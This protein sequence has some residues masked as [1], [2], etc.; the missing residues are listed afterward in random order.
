[1]QDVVAISVSQLNA[2]IKEVF[3]SDINLM[4]VTLKGEVS[5]FTNHVKTG[6]FYFT[7]KDKTSSIKAIMFKGN[8]SRVPFT[9]ENGMNVVVAGS[10]QV[11][12]RDGA[13]Q[14]YCQTLEPDGVG[15]LYLAFEQLKQKLFDKGLFDL[16]HKKPLPKMPAKIAVATAK[17]GAALQD[18]I[19]VLSRRYPLC[20][21]LVIPTLV[22]GANAPAS[23]I[24]SINKAQAE[25]DVDLLIIG[26]GGGSIEDLW[27]FNDEGV[28]N[29]IFTCKI[30][31]ISAVGHEVD[32]TIADFVA[33]LRAPTPSAAAELAVPDIS[34]LSRTTSGAAAA[35]AHYANL[36][37]KYR[38]DA[39]K[40]A[41]HRLVANSPEAKTTALDGEVNMLS[42]RLALSYA[43]TVDS[44]LQR[45]IKNVSMLD[46]LSPLAVI[47]RGYSITY[48]GEKIVKSAG[49]IKAHDVIKTRFS[50]GEITSIVQETIP[51]GDEF[52]GKD[53]I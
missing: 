40:T 23:I 35:L 34:E 6:H 3:A 30:P 19:N 18:I 36:Q 13:Y 48:K 47:T 29:A 51:K 15:A 33:D 52:V 53:D 28:A 5:N 2:Y 27:A 10:V 39:L 26:R 20:T 44:A 17:T 8:A 32:Y 49:E 41:Y 38:Y 7:I 42:Q 43:N 45:Y 16:A 12:E 11:F 46:A 22:Q 9:V 14:F 4:A 24:D 1:M 25:N 50:D 21:L 31:T 37:L